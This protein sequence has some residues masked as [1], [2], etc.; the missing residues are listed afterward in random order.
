MCAC[1][2]FFPREYSFA[3]RKFIIPLQLAAGVIVITIYTVTLLRFDPYVRQ[4][5]DHFHLHALFAIFT[6][7]MF[8]LIKDQEVQRGGHWGSS[9]WRDH[10]SSGVVYAGFGGVSAHFIT[11]S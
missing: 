11:L 1:L 8:G 4:D 6:F 9:E 10:V 5:D 3:N 7:L 2:V